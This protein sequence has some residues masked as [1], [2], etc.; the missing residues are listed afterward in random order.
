M[1][2]KSKKEKAVE[3]IDIVENE[4]IEDEVSEDK[5]PK[6]KTA[7]NKATK[8]RAAKPKMPESKIL[9]SA[10]EAFVSRNEMRV[11]GTVVRLFKVP[12]QQTVVLTIA[13]NAGGGA[14]S[15]FPRISFY[16][17]QSDTIY[18]ALGS[19]RKGSKHPQV[20]ITGSVQTTKRA[21]DDGFVYYQTAVGSSLS[22]ASTRLES[23]LNTEAGTRTVN[24]ENEVILIGE[25]VHIYRFE[26]KNA[27][28]I[29]TIKT[30]SNARI[31]FPKVTLFRDL[32]DLAQKMEAGDHI[33]LIG[34]LQ[35]KIS[36]KDGKQVRHE[37]IVGTDLDWYRE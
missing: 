15:N 10:P 11:T 9:V 24:D 8:D 17:S 27:G 16:G 33:A 22:F 31:D 26:R 25:I 14:V 18:K 3:A 19:V 6:G 20:T 36:E 1:A 5:A 12:N 32:N 35:T 34:M 4:A 29:L 21:R 7:N 30:T 23:I 28:T 13:T 37:N 2:L